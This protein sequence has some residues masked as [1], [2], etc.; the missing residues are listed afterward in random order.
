ML[1]G[2]YCAAVRGERVAGQGQVCRTAVPSLVAAM[3]GP[4]GGGGKGCAVRVAVHC[5]LLC[6]ECDQQ[7]RAWG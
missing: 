3:S 5:A 2:E 6:T 4:A 1:V 7:S